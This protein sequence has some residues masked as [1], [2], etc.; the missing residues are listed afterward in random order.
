MQAPPRHASLN[1]ITPESFGQRALD[2]QAKVSAYVGASHGG[3]GH[4]ASRGQCPN[5]PIVARGPR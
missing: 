3:R 5:R 2:Q 4:Q 1:Q